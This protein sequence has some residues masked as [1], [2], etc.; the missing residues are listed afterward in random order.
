MSFVGVAGQG[1]PRPL[2]SSLG[3]DCMD[4]AVQSI[5]HST[6]W[7]LQ[8]QKY[9]INQTKGWSDISVKIHER[10]RKPFITNILFTTPDIFSFVLPKATISWGAQLAQ[11][12]RPSHHT[13]PCSARYAG[14]L[15]C[16]RI[17]R[18]SHWLTMSWIHTKPCWKCNLLGWNI[19][20]EH[21]P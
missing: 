18:T 21:L 10:E 17:V 5:K 4:G 7:P 3:V 14:P 15:P 12:S 8:R 19:Q 16:A 13:P 6:A 1:H 11:P 20:A 2:L 9:A